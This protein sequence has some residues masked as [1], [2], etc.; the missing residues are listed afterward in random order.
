MSVNAQD[1]LNQSYF[2]ELR[3]ILQKDPNVKSLKLVQK[4][5]DKGKSIVQTMYVKFHDDPTNRYWSIGKS[6]VNDIKTGTL[7]YISKVEV[8]SRSLTDT[9]FT[10]DDWGNV[11]RMKIYNDTEEAI[12]VK[13]ILGF[14]SIFKKYYTN[15]PRQFKIIILCDNNVLYEENISYIENKG[16]MKHGQAIY[17]NPDGTIQKTENFRNGKLVQDE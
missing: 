13:D 6:F 5:S 11:V 8:N 7:R 12:P 4:K 14:L 1:T 9:C 10:Y 17:Y 2:N 15:H 16:F 3:G